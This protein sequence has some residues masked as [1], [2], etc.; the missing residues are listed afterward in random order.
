MY[1]CEGVCVRTC[2]RGCLCV[3]VYVTMYVR[4]DTCWYG[5]LTL[6]FRIMLPLSLVVSD[7][8]ILQLDE[9]ADCHPDG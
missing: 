2:V 3:K 8:E 6:D 5:S 7:P 4:V 9:L 1:V